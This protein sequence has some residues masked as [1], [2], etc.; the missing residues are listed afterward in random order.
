MRGRQ[1]SIQALA[2][3]YDQL[4][5]EPEQ[6]CIGIAHCDCYPDVQ[7][8]ITL[9]NRNHPP[10]EIMTVMYEP[11]TGAHVGPGALALFFF[12][13]PASRELAKS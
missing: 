5:E 11:V 4:V 13:N 10:R 8:L 1:A 9:L 12:G 6:Q 2:D 7:T 3:R